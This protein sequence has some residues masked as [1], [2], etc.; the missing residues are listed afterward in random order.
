MQAVSNGQSSFDSPFGFEGCSLIAVAKKKAKI[1]A[2]TIKGII[3]LVLF[4]EFFNFFLQITF[5]H[6]SLSSFSQNAAQKRD[7]SHIFDAKRKRILLLLRI[8][9]VFIAFGVF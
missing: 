7:S 6:F 1:T 2:R 5:K 4:E 9:L 3:S 8:Y